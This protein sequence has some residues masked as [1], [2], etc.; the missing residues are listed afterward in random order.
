MPCDNKTPYYNE[1]ASSYNELHGPEQIE[2]ARTIKAALSPRGLLLDVGA[3]TGIATRVF[4]PECR[5]VAL[6]PSIGMLQQYRGLKVCGRA[7]EI[8]FKDNVFDCIVSITALH[9]TELEKAFAE[10]LR[11]A[12]PG[13]KI[14]ISFFKRARLLP[15]A[16]ELFAGF[17]KIDSKFDVVFLRK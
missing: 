16:E 17:E 2:K 1:I 7:E 6:E 3:G 5:C 8:P 10:I 14:G 11:V 9:H 15:K 4:E 13:A 12:K